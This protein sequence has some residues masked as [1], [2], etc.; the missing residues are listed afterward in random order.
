LNQHLVYDDNVYEG[1]NPPEHVQIKA[2][3]GTLQ[4]QSGSASVPM[5]YVAMTV[6]RYNITQY[7]SK[8]SRAKIREFW[9]VFNQECKTYA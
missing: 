1:T 6:P 9:S 5:D 3:Q 7:T 2:A 8:S 4:L